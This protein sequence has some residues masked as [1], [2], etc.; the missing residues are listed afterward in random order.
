[1]T[2]VIL[3]AIRRV[4]EI[5]NLNM[6]LRI[7][8]GHLIFVCLFAACAPGEPTSTEATVTDLAPAAE[9]IEKPAKTQDPAGVALL[10]QAYVAHGGKHFDK[11]RYGFTFRGKRYNFI[12]EGNYRIYSRSYTDGDQVVYE[13]IQNEKY[14]KT[15]NGTSVQLT[16]KEISTGYE[17]LN[18]V[19]YF[20]TLPYKLKDASVNLYVA[21][22]TTI[23]GKAYDVLKVNFDQEGG[24]VDFNDNFLYWINQETKRIDYLAYDYKTNK[25]GVRFRSAYN[26]RTVEGVLFQDYINF[27]APLGTTLMNLPEMYEKGGLEE[28]SRIETEDVEQLN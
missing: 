16:E 13:G 4:T 20:A 17:S 3:I 7:L 22:T 9:P 11:A 21:G 1:M 28:L 5:N 19:I 10:D 8:L 23:K 12:A 6:I 27:K 26:P 15:I 24:G 14:T 25:G 2:T 18:S